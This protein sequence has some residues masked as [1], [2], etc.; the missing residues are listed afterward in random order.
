[1]VSVPLSIRR[2]GIIYPV[3]HRSKAQLAPPA[4][5]I[6]GIQDGGVNFEIG[7]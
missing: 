3:S 6:H 7:Y 1:M 4:K 2:N 5:N